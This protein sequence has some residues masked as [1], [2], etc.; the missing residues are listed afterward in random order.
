MLCLIG[1]YIQ[2]NDITVI[3]RG[4]RDVIGLIVILMLIMTIASL[5]FGRQ[6]RNLF[7]IFLYL[8]TSTILSI[9]TVAMFKQVTTL[10]CPWDVV[11]FGGPHINQAFAS[12][13]PVG[14]CFPSGHAS[15]GFALFSFYFAAKIARHQG[16]FDLRPKNIKYFLIPGLVTGGIFGIA[17]Q[18]RGAH[19]LSHDIASAAICWL[20]CG[21]LWSIFHPKP[22]NIITSQ[23][24]PFKLWKWPEK[25]REIRI[26]SNKLYD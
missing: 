12:N 22:N 17:Q 1:H 11:A 24:L 8:T 23:Y 7:K 16:I 13:L 14:H 26:N 6:A 9:A 10:P 18:L 19:F 20:I 3:H 15:G 5:A 2:L 25:N 21:L 4:G